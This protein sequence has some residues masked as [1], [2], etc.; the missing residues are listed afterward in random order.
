[1]VT[2]L[3]FQTAI[4]LSA[5]A[6]LVYLNVFVLLLRQHTIGAYPQYVLPLSNN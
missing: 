2:I 4:P 1:M 5:W 6:T 3:K